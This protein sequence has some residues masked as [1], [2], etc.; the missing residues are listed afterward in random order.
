MLYPIELLGHEVDAPDGANRTACMLT[1]RL[2]FVMSSLA[3]EAVVQRPRR[4]VQKIV[5]QIATHQND[6]IAMCNGRTLRQ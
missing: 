6:I 4:G 3:L 5:V 2:G 1:A